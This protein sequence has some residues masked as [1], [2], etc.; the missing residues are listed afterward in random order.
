MLR[1][2][3][4]VFLL[5]LFLPFAFYTEG[6]NCGNVGV[7]SCLDDAECVGDKCSANRCYCDKSNGQGVCKPTTDICKEDKDC[8]TP[9]VCKGGQ[10]K[11]PSCTKDSDCGPNEICDAL[12][13]KCVPKTPDGCTADAECTGEKI[14]CDFG[15]GTGKKCNFRRCVVDEDCRAGGKNT[16][17]QPIT[18]NENI[19]PSCISGQCKCQLPCGG[20]DC[21]EGKCCNAEQDQCVNNPTPCESLTCDKGFDKPDPTQFKVDPATCK[22]TGPDCRCV[23]KPPLELGE[24]GLFSEIGLVNG[25]VVVS[26]Y[27]KTYGDL[28]VGTR[29]A[30]GSFDWEFVDGV[31]TGGAVT[32][33]VDG[34]RGGVGDP[35]DDVGKHTSLAVGAGG[36]LHIS[37]YDETNGTLK[38]AR[39]E[40]GTWSI[41]V[42]DN[43]GKGVGRFTSITLD[44]NGVPAIAYFVMTDTAGDSVLRVARGKVPAPK[45]DA[46]WLIA[47]AD[48]AKLPSCSG[49]CDAAK[50]E[51]CVNDGGQAVCRAPTADA[52]KC[53]TPC[54]AKGEICWNDL[55]LKTIEADPNPPLPPG[56]G[57]FP[58]VAA[59]DGGGLVVAYY[60]NLKG[61]LKLAKQESAS[62]PFT[63]TVLSKGKRDE[64]QFPSVAVDTAGRI[65]IAYINATD[66]EVHYIRLDKDLKVEKE[67]LVDDGLIDPNGGDKRMLADCSLAVDSLGEP[68]IVY[69]DATTQALKIAVR[70]GDNMWKKEKLAGEDTPYRGAFGFFADQVIDNDISHISNYKVNLR[71]NDNNIDIRTWKK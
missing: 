19:Q 32:G 3:S 71:A 8:P 60:D 51:V 17:I 21:G 20:A 7:F 40:G 43:N 13:G 31:P 30:D 48:S 26:G 47:D 63:P 58:S 62:V 54:A 36:T 42:V 70:E 24:N 55:C 52:D 38:Y 57:L 10:C 16:C 33:A 25:Q 53:K 45:A 35:G 46:D 65:H 69:Q 29:K 41:H 44:S 5:F 4:R 68:R 61:L 66:T 64:G 6:C 14:C 18:C 12:L 34:P 2:S 11:D 28:V 22:L 37:Y 23:K 49:T 39:K 50:K 9:L 56:V 1:R 59:V 67:E 27:N 15:N